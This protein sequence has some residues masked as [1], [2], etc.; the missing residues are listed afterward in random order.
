[1]TTL[2]L[3][4]THVGC[5]TSNCGA[6]TVHVNGDAVKSC[7][8]LAVQA[9]GAEVTTIE[10]MGPEGALHPLQEAFWEH[11]GLQCGY[12]TPGMIMAS[13]DLLRAQPDAVRGRRCAR[14]SPATSAAVRA[15]TTSSRPSWR[16][17][18]HDGNRRRAL[19]VGQ[20]MQRKEDP[21]LITGRARYVDDITPP[22][23]L[24]C[25]FVRSP[26]AHAK[27]TSIDK[28]AAEQRPRRASP[29]SPATTWRPRHRRRAADGLGAARRRG[30]TTRRTGRSPRTRST[31]SATRSRV[32]IGDGRYADRR[33]PPRRC[34]SSTSRCRSVTDIEAALEDG[35]PLVHDELGTNECH[36]W[37]LGGGDIEAALRR[38]ADVVIE[39][40]VVNHR[41]AGAPIEPRGVLADCRAA[42][43]D[44]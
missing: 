30:Q 1:M 39:R 7:T 41:I 13:A 25:S 2:G 28:S 14:R 37:S 23:T 27:I 3:T 11:H 4:G 42:A 15:T 20:A 12:C 26:E 29:S 17:P 32:V 40:R 19:F 5:D 8:L 38:A 33:T 34:S 21:R 43:A 6:C 10:G 22:G 9:D 24:W 31:T 36:Q 16:P 35:S 18:T 44:V